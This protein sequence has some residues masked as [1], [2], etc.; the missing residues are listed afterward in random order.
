MRPVLGPDHEDVPVLDGE[1]EEEH[2]GQ[3][4]HNDQDDHTVLHHQHPAEGNWAGSCQNL[5]GKYQFI[6]L[7]LWVNFDHIYCFWA[8]SGLL[9]VS[10]ISVCYCTVLC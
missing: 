5:C 6:R 1:P 8:Y 9:N 7:E 10:P 4:G 2:G 3:E